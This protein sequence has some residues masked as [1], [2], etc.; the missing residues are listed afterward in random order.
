MK[1]TIFGATGKIA[2]ILIEYALEEGHVITGVARDPSKMTLTHKNLSVIKADMNNLRDVEAA[3][4]G[5][6][7]VVEGVASYAEGTK[8]IVTA[9]Q[10]LGVKRLIAVS[11]YSAGDPN[12]GFHLGFKVAVY[13]LSII[14]AN[15]VRNVR[16]AAQ[17]IRASDLDWTLLRVLGLSDKPPTNRIVYGYLGKQKLGFSITR[18]DMA[19]AILDQLTDTTHLHRAPAISN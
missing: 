8:T 12:D 17:V 1:I 6:D 11:T 2:R 5:A 19:R 10:N 3:I 18:G 16:R 15:P 14:I 13:L 4:S 7:A 9:M